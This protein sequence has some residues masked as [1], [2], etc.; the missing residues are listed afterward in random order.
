MIPK[1][2]QDLEPH[3][4]IYKNPQ[5]KL[6]GGFVFQEDPIYIHLRV[7]SYKAFVLWSIKSF[8][9]LATRLP[10]NGYSSNSQ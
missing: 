3:A 2:L 9:S 5:A 6:N 7:S 8:L 1:D 4:S 10:S